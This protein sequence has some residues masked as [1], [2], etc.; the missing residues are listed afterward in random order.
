M[1]GAEEDK[2]LCYSINVDGIRNIARHADEL[3]IKVLHISTDYVFD[4]CS[5]RPYTEGDKVNP[6]SEYGN[7]KRRGETALLGLSPES[8]IV[9]TGWLYSPHG[10]NFLKTMLRLGSERP[11]IKVV[12]DQIGTPTYA[13]DLADAI[14]TMVLT[15]RWMPGIYHFANEGACSWYDFAVAIMEYAG[16]GCKVTPITS[17]DFPSAVSRPPFSVLDKSRIKTTYGITIPHWQNALRR[18]VQRTI[19]GAE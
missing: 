3:G 12:F 2:H 13:R 4:G 17:A 16:L 19:A 18:C 5:C 15:S 9:R 10:R 7:T 8:I 14:A 1:E 6:M 11:E